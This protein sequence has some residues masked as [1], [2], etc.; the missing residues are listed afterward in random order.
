MI[1][2]TDDRVQSPDSSDLAAR[3]GVGR[4]AAMSLSVGRYL[5]S[6]G[7]EDCRELGQWLLQR[8]DQRG[9]RRRHLRPV[10]DQRQFGLR[11]SGPSSVGTPD[12]LCESVLRCFR[13]R[14]GAQDLRKKSRPGV[15]PA[16]A[17]RT[18]S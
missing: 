1:E 16:A 4:L 15:R 7:P 8:A 10:R 9:V 5:R 17:D 13:P 18:G 3:D 14:D 6:L 11:D 2:R 12:L